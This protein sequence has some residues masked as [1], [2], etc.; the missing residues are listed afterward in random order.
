MTPKRCVYQAVP[1]WEHHLARELEGTP[2]AR[3]LLE[4]LWEAPPPKG[5]PGDPVWFRLLW[6][7]PESL[8]FGSAAEAARLL[9]E[10]NGLWVEFLPR[11]YR[12]GMLIKDR[13]PVFRPKPLEFP[14]APPTARIG[15]W[16]L[17]DEHTLLCS[18]ETDSPFPGGVAQFVPPRSP[19]PSA[20]YRKLQEAL[21]LFRARWGDIP[22]PGDWCLDAGASPGGWSWVLAG[23]GCRVLAVDRGPLA[24]TVA[25]R[26]EVRFLQGDGLRIHPARLAR[27]GWAPFDWVF[28]DMAA[29]PRKVLSWVR[30]WLEA[31]RPPRMVVTVKVSGEPDWDTLRGFQAL[32]GG[33]LCHL[34]HNKHELTWMWAPPN[35]SFTSTARR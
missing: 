31:P 2:G 20:A 28:S 16:T 15:A 8:T 30:L 3:R 23:L 13:L 12:R 27:E 9:R 5:G 19:P 7:Q 10:R 6:L 4:G 24:P 26:E 17:L 1:E 21:T 11:H 34:S 22:K 14:K 32:G 25:A 18:A 33:R 29:L 35:Q